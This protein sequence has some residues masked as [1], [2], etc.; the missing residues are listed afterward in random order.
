[1]TEVIGNPGN[2]G[3]AERWHAAARGEVVDWDELLGGYRATVDW[4]G[5]S[6]WEALRSRWPEARVLL[7]KRDPDAWYQSVMRTIRPAS[8]HLRGES[9]ESLRSAGEMIERL[10][11]QNTFDRRIEDRDHAVAVYERHNAAVEA[12]VPPELLLVFEPGEG[13]ER[14]C[15][16]LGRPVPD[17]PFPHANSSEEFLGRFET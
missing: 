10:I 2:A 12:A 13:W 14:L 8:Q 15:A 5:C 4:P 9:D 3:H 16:F 1:M 6:F 7:S 11:W 17:E